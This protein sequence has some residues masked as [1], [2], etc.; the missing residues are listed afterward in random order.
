MAKAM[1][2]GTVW[3]RAIASRSSRGIVYCPPETIMREFFV[4]SD[5]TS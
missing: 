5:H 1:W 3:P 2:N 4:D